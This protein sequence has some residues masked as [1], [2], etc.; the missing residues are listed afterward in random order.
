MKQ[1]RDGERRFRAVDCKAGE[2]MEI[3]G[4]Q[5]HRVIKKRYRDVFKVDIKKIQ[6]KFV[7]YYWTRQIKKVF[8]GVFYDQH[9][10]HIRHFTNVCCMNIEWINNPDP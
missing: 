9:L 7:K 10:A 8:F 4:C 2:Q 6:T 3:N 1:Q 5:T